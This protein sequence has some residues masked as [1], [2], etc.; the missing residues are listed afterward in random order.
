MKKITYT[1]I[2]FLF[3]TFTTK[4]QTT[5]D[6]FA[7][8]ATYGSAIYLTTDGK[9][10]VDNP[11]V[12][13]PFKA[14]VRF[15]RGY[16]ASG[17]QPVDVTVSLIYNESGAPSTSDLVISTPLRITQS[18][19]S[20]GSALVDKLIDATLPANKTTG[21]IYVKYTWYMYGFSDG[22]KYPNPLTNYSN[23][24]YSIAA[25][26]APTIL[27]TITLLS[28]GNYLDDISISGTTPTGGAITDVRWEV[29]DNFG[30]WY[31]IE[32]SPRFPISLSLNNFL[33][34]GTLEPADWKQ[35]RRRL[36]IGNTITY[37]NAVSITTPIYSG[38]PLSIQL[39]FAT[40]NADGIFI[41]GTQASFTLTNPSPN[42]VY[43]WFYA[44]TDP[45]NYYGPELSYTKEYLSS[46]SS[47]TF[48]IKPK[49]HPWPNELLVYGSD[50]SSQSYSLP[51]TY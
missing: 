4:G 9:L 11:S 37:S 22:Y 19:F 44:L 35:I 17:L 33:K 5:L 25:V 10:K 14:E 28:S 30:N 49:R 51:S 45:I 3:S 21:R 23:N 18:D 27:N 7:I 20:S 31:R 13:T 41:N 12:A 48:E 1:L 8:P 26:Q 43:K 6:R 36:T 2:I 50:G 24:Y 47:T 15:M 46:G 42:V 32:N 39:N 38:S 34:P 16:I 40:Q 29:L